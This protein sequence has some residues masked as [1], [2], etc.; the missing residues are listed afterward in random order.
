MILH[1]LIKAIIMMFLL[2]H[3]SPA[4][5]AV[6]ARVAVLPFEIYS[7]ESTASLKDLIAQDI[8]THLAA[9]NQL[10]VVDQARIRNILADKASLTFN[11]VTLRTISEKL[12]A[13][14]LVLGSMTRIGETISLDTYIFNAGS[15]PAFTKEFSEGKN[16]DSITKEMAGKV[17]AHIL[18]VLPPPPEQ[19]A[20]E[21]Q[22]EIPP[23]P[24]ITPPEKPMEEEAV[25]ADTGEVKEQ[26]LEEAGK[27]QTTFAPSPPP[28]EPQGTTAEL[29]P[30]E[31]A[32]KRSRS[33]PEKADKEG[34]RSSPFSSAKPVKITSE[35]LEA[36]NK[37]NL[38]TFK[39]NVVAKQGDMV[40]LADTMTV[41]YE[42]EGG[43][44]RVEASGNVK[45]SQ[46]NRIATGTRIVFYN[47]EQKIVMTGN[48]KIWQGDNLI[49]CEKITV[50]LEEDRI[51][52]EGK[53]DSTIFPKSIEEDKKKDTKNIEAIPSHSDEPLSANGAPGK[54]EPAPLQ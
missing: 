11:E 53:V 41:D 54:A 21:P 43:I 10:E 16:L 8:S 5:A 50:L 23:T 7:D 39:G 25:A 31:G 30:D 1:L 15:T 40:I 26:Q 48:P 19:K 17:N 51:F 22:E 32:A 14:F 24:E 13:P 12:G 2:V 38:V 33:K 49:S 47:P 44:K 42:R 46:E 9:G 37:R 3:A 36:D 27:P 28:S 20:V 4:L 29:Q 6:T 45:M 52:F 34:F 18:L 35:S